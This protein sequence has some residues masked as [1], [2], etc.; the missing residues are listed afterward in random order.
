VEEVGLVAELP[1]RSPVVFKLRGR[2]IAI[3]RVGERVYAL[4][5]VCPHQTQSFRGGS[6]HGRIVGDPHHLG[7]IELNEADPVLACPW[8]GWEFDLKTGHCIVD[9]KLRVR[10]YD[11][12][13]EDGRVFVDVEPRLP[14]GSVS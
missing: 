2:E 6:A 1:D 10:A 12:T 13:V 9:R 7:D 3:I 4:R 8:H 11:V 5:N 14:T